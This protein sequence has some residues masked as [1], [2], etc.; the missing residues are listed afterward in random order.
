MLELVG[1]STQLSDYCFFCACCDTDQPDEATTELTLLG[2][3]AAVAALGGASPGAGTLRSASPNTA[4]KVWPSLFDDK[5]LI[6][7][8]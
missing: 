3:T 2:S 7:I 1:K 5:Y 6:S 4:A 8:F